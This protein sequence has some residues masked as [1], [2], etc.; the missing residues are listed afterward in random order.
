[1]HLIYKEQNCHIFVNIIIIFKSY[2]HKSRLLNLFV[3]VPTYFSND[4]TVHFGMHYF[5]RKSLLNEHTWTEMR[6]YWDWN[7]LFAFLNLNSISMC[8]LCQ[9]RWC[10]SS[11]SLGN[12]WN[13]TEELFFSKMTKYWVWV[14]NNNNSNN[15]NSCFCLKFAHFSANIMSRPLFKSS[16]FF[17]MFRDW[18][19]C[20]QRYDVICF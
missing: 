5:I 11:Y 8:G 15:S 17:L 13:N 6:E 18:F 1:L 4:I 9:R 3:N 20:E 16:C 10:W 2:L 19:K 7:Y 12:V 14:N